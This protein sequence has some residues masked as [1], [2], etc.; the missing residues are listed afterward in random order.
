[1]DPLLHTRD[2]GI[3]KTMDF[4]GETARTV[5]SAGKVMATVFWDARG[6][7]HVDYLPS[8]QTINGDYYATL[9]NNNNFQQ[10]FKEK[11]FP[12]DKKENTL[13]SRQC[14]DSYVPGTDGQMQRIPLRI[15]SPVYS[16]NLVSCD[17]FLFPNLKK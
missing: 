14:T 5:K 15:A 12:F 13:S 8:K 6:I 3:V 16:P 10:H 7:I 2:E 4:T 11:T 1:M 9:L 17:Y